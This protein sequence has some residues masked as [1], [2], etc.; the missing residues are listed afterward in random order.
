[1]AK[2]NGDK[3]IEF[4]ATVDEVEAIRKLAS[5]ERCASIPE[6]I[7]MALNSLA[8]ESGDESFFLEPRRGKHES[9]DAV[10]RSVDG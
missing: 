1:M 3:R 4:P 5:R 2:R 10:E 7:R 6:L 8:E 9:T